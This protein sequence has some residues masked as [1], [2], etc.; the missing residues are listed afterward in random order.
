M[1]VGLLLPSLRVIARAV[2]TDKSRLVR[3]GQ[4]VGHVVAM[5]GD[6]VNDSAAL[7]ASDVGF[8]M[9]SGC[10]LELYVPFVPISLAEVAKEAAD[11]VILDDNVSS[12]AQAVLYG[13][14]IFRLAHSELL[15]VF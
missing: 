1:H 11:I 10:T 4:S 6:G 9:G 2:P 3:I 7:K 14:T 13:R 5:T 8:A 12:I 15:F